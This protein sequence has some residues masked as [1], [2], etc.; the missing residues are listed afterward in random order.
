MS[1]RQ[2]LETYFSELEKER[3]FTVPET[4]HYALLRELLNV[5]GA[6]LQ[7]VVRAYVHPNNTGAGIPDIGLFGENQEQGQKPT[8][9]VIEA[10]PIRDNIQTIAQSAQVVSQYIPHY[11][12]VLATNFY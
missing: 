1:F 2:A 5:V 11:G 12:Q 3:N 10:K 7:P 9:G 4:S 6:E 8:H